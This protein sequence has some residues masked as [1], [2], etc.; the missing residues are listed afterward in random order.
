MAYWP[1]LTED[2]AEPGMAVGERPYGSAM[3]IVWCGIF[4]V[5]WLVVYGLVRMA[6][7]RPA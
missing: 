5:A 1:A 3:I 7:S 2:H 6:V 4:A